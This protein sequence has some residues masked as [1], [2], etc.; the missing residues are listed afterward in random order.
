MKSLFLN[1]MRCQQPSAEPTFRPGVSQSRHHHVLLAKGRENLASLFLVSMKVWPRPVPRSWTMLVI[2]H[3][4]RLSEEHHALS[5]A[6]EFARVAD[7]WLIGRF[8]VTC[9][10]FRMSVGSTKR[11]FQDSRF[12]RALKRFKASNFSLAQSS[13]FSAPTSLWT[14]PGKNTKLPRWLKEL[15]LSVPD[16]EVIDLKWASASRL[17]KPG[18]FNA[19]WYDRGRRASST[20]PTCGRALGGREWS[21][22]PYLN[23]N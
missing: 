20:E 3:S 23:R 21:M 11:E 22:A 17:F 8:A 16:E 6:S 7:N 15:D 5:Q 18:D 13:D 10:K 14:P 4:F 1:G 12:P 2:A 19:D 9:G